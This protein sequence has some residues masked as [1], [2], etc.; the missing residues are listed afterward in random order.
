MPSART[1]CPDCNSDDILD[2]RNFLTSPSYDYFRC[3]GCSCWWM[4]PSDADA[5]ATRV[6]LG[7]RKTSARVAATRVCPKCG[8]QATLLDMSLF[9]RVNYYRCARCSHLYAADPQV[10]VPNDEATRDDDKAS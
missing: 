4:L 10:S 6:I 9:A 7:N 3:H 8:S 1:H 5:P 2:L